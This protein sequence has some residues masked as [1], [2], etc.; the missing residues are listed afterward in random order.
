[1]FPVT[2][3][4]KKTAKKSWKWWN[5]WWNRIVSRQRALS[6]VGLNQL[7]FSTFVTLVQGRHQLIKIKVK[8]KLQGRR[9]FLFLGVFLLSLIDTTSHFPA[10][11]IKR[12]LRLNFNQHYNISAQMLL[13]GPDHK[14][15]ALPSTRWKGPAWTA[16]PGQGRGRAE[17]LTYGWSAEPGARGDAAQPP[18]SAE[19][20]SG[21]QLFWPVG[22]SSSLGRKQ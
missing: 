18:A 14:G 1:M 8:A 6:L 7:S 10:G 13:S 22:F 19:A 16:E 17:P 21:G 11:C 20:L 12:D 2:S 5:R 15:V 3:V 4:F 9:C